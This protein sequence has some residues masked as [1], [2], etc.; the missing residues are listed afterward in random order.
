MTQRKHPYEKWRALAILFFVTH[1]G[2]KE[3]SCPGLDATLWHQHSEEYQTLCR[4]LYAHACLRLKEA[5]ETPKWSADI[6]QMSAETLP[7]ETAVVLDIDETVLNN[8]PLF[9]RL[10][11][12]GETDIGKAWREW[13]RESAATAI[14]GAALFVQSALAEGIHVF[15]V[16]NR[17]C[18]MDDATV[19]N[20]RNVGF[21]VDDP[22][23]HFLSRNTD[24]VH[25]DHTEECPALD[26]TVKALFNVD[27]P[28]FHA[29]KGTRRA[30]IASKFRVLML[31]G[32]SQGD[33]YSLPPKKG[34]PKPE[35]AR[36]LKAQLTPK[37]RMTI[38]TRYSSFFNDRWIQLPN[39]M[40][41]NWL[42]SR[43]G[44]RSAPIGEIVQQRLSLLDL[45]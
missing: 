6:S 14:E 38:N 1:I 45:N 37:E 33:F 22:K 41:G 43:T 7:E 32:D 12:N 40:Y 28:K 9:A 26:R 23:V 10:L 19:R 36:L 29:Y 2:C 31:I 15:F 27:T 24:F 39:A 21:P 11:K 42:S 30:L 8:A 25:I 20:M 35:R 4:N 16:S 5:K 13:A 3:T 44:Y 18:T 17:S 34:A